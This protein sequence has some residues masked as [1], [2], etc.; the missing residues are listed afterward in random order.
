MGCTLGP[1]LTEM[2]SEGCYQVHGFTPDPQAIAAVTIMLS[3]EPVMNF[4]PI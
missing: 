4:E 1:I 3:P 2:K